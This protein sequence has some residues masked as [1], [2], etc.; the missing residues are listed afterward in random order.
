MSQVGS[1]YASIAWSC[2]S[3]LV[4]WCETAAFWCINAWCICGWNSRSHWG[5]PTFAFP[6]ACPLVSSILLLVKVAISLPQET[7]SNVPL[8][9]SVDLRLNMLT[10]LPKVAVR[11]RSRIY[12]LHPE[13]NGAV[14]IS[15]SNMLGV[16]VE[17]HL[18]IC[19]LCGFPAPADHSTQLRG[20]SPW[21]RQSPKANP[22]WSFHVSFF[23]LGISALHNQAAR[24]KSQ[25]CHF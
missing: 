18:L 4:E 12:A 13:E 23:F 6:G 10:M 15:V 22:F 16:Q 19:Y 24:G 5:T 25:M 20:R 14:G 21:Y 17:K 1:G 8:D 9:N 11:C 3:H 7:T 2:D